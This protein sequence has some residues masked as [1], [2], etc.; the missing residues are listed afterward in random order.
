MAR[1][2]P[3]YEEG[4]RKYWTRHDAHLWMRHDAWRFMPPGTPIYTGRDVV[5]YGEPNFGRPTEEELRRAQVEDEAFQRDLA[6]LRA[7]LAKLNAEIE[8]RRQRQWREAKR[9]SDLRW[10]RFLRKVKAGFNPDQPRVPAGNPDGGQWTSEDGEGTTS[11]GRLRSERPDVSA[12][13]R[14]R[15]HHF[16]HQSLYR[17]LP[18]RPETRR[19]FE[20]ATTG[21]LHSQRHGWS[22]DHDRYNQGVAE[23]FDRFTASNSIRPEDMTPDQARSFVQEIRSSTDPRVRDFNMRILRQEFQYYLRRI[24]RSRE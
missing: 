1:I 20:D 11:A 19:V 4:Q 3:A 23:H 7:A 8:A 21:P 12:A 14:A 2:D 9:L 15:G 17:N 22:R 5:K 24:P 16:V 18:L 6:E 13:R 10:Q